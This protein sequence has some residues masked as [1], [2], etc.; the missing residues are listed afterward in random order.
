MK[1]LNCLQTANNYEESRKILETLGL[2]VK[3]Y[4]KYG[5]YLVKYDK[6]QSN[7]VDLDVQRCRGLIFSLDNQVLSIPPSKSIP[8]QSF[9]NNATDFESIRFEEFIDGTM[10]QMFYFNDKW[11]IATRSSIGANCRWY[12][13]KKFSELFNESGQKLNMDKLETNTCYTFVLKHSENRIV[14]QYED[15]SIVLV[16]ATRITDDK[17]EDLK[18]DTLNIGVET[19]KVFNFSNMDEAIEACSNFNFD[20]QG[21]VLKYEKDGQEIRSK[22]RNPKYNSAKILRGNTNNLK[23]QFLEL[24]QNGYLAQYLDYFPE[25]N[26]L[27]NGYTTEL[28]QVT[29]NLFN[30]YQ[31]IHVRRPKTNIKQIP[32]EYRPLCY[33]LHGMF[34]KTGAVTTFGRVKNYINT[35]DIPRLLFVINYRYRERD[36]TSDRHCVKENNSDGKGEVKNNDNDSNV[37]ASLS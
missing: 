16:K 19:P 33:E 23:Y 35:M 26:D 20:E 4:S 5:M 14:K 1:Y 32:F 36:T 27:F 30:Y 12:S 24:R 11:N 34:I 2:K 37:E 9:V 22:L 3:D 15:C 17:I 29:Q 7:M 8:F 28:Y 18:L 6:N 31:K 10:V 13:N 25:H 21:L